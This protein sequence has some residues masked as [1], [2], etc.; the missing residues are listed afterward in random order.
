MLSYNS[1][2]YKKVSSLVLRMFYSQD[3]RKEVE[4]KLFSIQI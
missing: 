4:T 2:I 1:T 3:K